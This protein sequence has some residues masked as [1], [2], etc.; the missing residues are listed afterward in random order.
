LGGKYQHVSDYKETQRQ[1]R[2]PEAIKTGR[3]DNSGRK[4]IGKKEGDSNNRG[5]ATSSGK[6]KT[7][8]M[9]QIKR[10]G[11]EKSRPMRGLRT[12]RGENYN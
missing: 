8:L 1:E 4:H 11:E 10:G 3:G 5:G 6:R 7:L 2:K 9:A 12:I